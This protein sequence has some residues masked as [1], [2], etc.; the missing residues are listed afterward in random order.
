MLTLK[1]GSNDADNSAVHPRN[2]LLF[3]IYKNRKQSFSNKNMFK[4][5]LLETLAKSFYIN[6]KDLCK[7]HLNTF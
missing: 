3:K 5:I 1:T 4:A 7:Q 2:K 6:L